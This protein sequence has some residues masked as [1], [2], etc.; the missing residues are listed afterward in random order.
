MSFATNVKSEI[1]KFEGTKTENIALLSGFVRNNGTV[2]ENKIDLITENSTIAKKIYQL[3]KEVY[4]ISLEIKTQKNNN[5]SKKNLYR[6]II[7]TDLKKI[8][9]DLSVVK[10]HKVL[11]KPDE[12]IISGEEEMRCYLMGAFLSK[13]SINDPKTARYH[14]EF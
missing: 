6:L 12:Y 7:E 3:F 5:L 8:L 11:E 1:T 14:L 10:D 9:E 2:N 13:G 4:H